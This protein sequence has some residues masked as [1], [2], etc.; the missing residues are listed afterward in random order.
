M[1]YIKK[2]NPPLAVGVKIQ[3]QSY[4]LYESFVK[5]VQSF[6]PPVVFATKHS[7]KKKNK[8]NARQ[9]NRLL[10]PKLKNRYSAIASRF[11]SKAFSCQE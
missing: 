5:V 10:L 7:Q 8:D 4:Q 11:K 6:Q 3:D 2:N 1:F 9:G